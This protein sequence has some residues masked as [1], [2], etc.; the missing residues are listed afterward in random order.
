MCNERDR[1][2]SGLEDSSLNIFPSCALLFW[3]D[4]MNYKYMNIALNEAKK[5]FVKNE[6]PVGA[7]IVKNGVVISKAYNKKEKNY[8]ALCHAEI[9][10]IKKASKKLKNWRLEDC[11]MYI[12]LEPCPMCASAIR[13]ARIKTV[14]AG[15]HNSNCENLNLIKQIFCSKS[16]DNKVDFYNDI[17]P[18]KVLQLM[19]LF[20][21]N[22][23]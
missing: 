21:N 2:R 11:E 7:V 8:C 17:C 20:F 14:Y 5:A 23:R 18:E 4:F 1:N 13:Q 12:T 10:A 19:Q 9:L 22:R 6:V 16:H 15:L 3:G